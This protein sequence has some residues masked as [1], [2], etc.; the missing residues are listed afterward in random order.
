MGRNECEKC[1][2][3]CVECSCEEQKKDYNVDGMCAAS[4]F[5]EQKC[6]NFELSNVESYTD[7]KYCNHDD[8]CEWKRP[9]RTTEPPNVERTMDYTTTQYS[10][11]YTR[12][13]VT[14]KFE[15]TYWSCP[16]GG[17]LAFVTTATPSFWFDIVMYMLKKM[18][19]VDV[20]DNDTITPPNDN[21]TC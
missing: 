11:P 13:F 17:Y 10:E 14:K 12:A 8:E 2:M 9:A 21:K 5:E 15:E 18:R 20:I 6:K 16:A 1:G 19:F 3:H 7:C 4:S